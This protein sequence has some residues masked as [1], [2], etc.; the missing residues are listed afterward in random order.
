MGGLDTKENKIDLLAKEHFMAHVYLWAIHRFEK[1]HVQATLALMAM[2]KGSLKGLR[3]D[4]QECTL[5]SEEYQQ[6]REDFS[7]LIAPILSEANKGPN[8]PAFGKHWYKDPNSNR[9]SMFHDGGQPNGWIRGKQ[10]KIT[11]EEYNKL[12]EFNKKQKQLAKEAWL[13]ETQEMADY[14]TNYGYEATCKKFKVSMSQEA[15]LMKFIKARQKY[16]IK[17]ISMRLSGKKRI[18]KTPPPSPEVTQTKNDT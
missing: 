9:C 3:Q 12:K 17:F 11:E 16:G 13:Q 1:F 6:A 15:M 10:K 14:Y 18:F 8:N 4:L 7:K 2:H 5:A